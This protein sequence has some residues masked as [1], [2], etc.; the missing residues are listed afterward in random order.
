MTKRDHIQSAM[1][2]HGVVFFLTAVLAAFGIWSLPHLNKD[3]FP[4]FTVR[5]GIIVAIYPGATAQEV[6]QQVTAQ[7]ENFLFNV[8]SI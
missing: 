8:S 5:Q 4:Q 1:R 6:E 3:E 2:N 7:L